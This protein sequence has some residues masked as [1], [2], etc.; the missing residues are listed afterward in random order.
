MCP[1]C[2]VQEYGDPNY[3]SQDLLGHLKLR[4]KFDL[5][6]YTNYEQTDDDILAQV[7]AASMQDQ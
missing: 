2:I 3:V 5:D 7:L 4:H 6:T 1:I